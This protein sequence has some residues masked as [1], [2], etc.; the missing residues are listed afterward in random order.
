[1]LHYARSN[2][3]DLPSDNNIV[4]RIY[5]NIKGLAE[6]CCKAGIISKASTVEDFTRGFTRSKHLFDFVD[7]GHGKDRADDKLSGGLETI[8]FPISLQLNEKLNSRGIQIA[9]I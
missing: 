5:A 4:V 7:V 6:T 8:C 1:M 2:L 3:E 9:F